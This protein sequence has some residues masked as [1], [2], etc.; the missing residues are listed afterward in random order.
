LK[1]ILISGCAGEERE[2]KKC[3]SVHVSSLVRLV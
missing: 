2:A 3:D 1:T